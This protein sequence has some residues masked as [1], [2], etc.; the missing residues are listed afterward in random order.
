MLEAHDEVSRRTR[1]ILFAYYMLRRTSRHAG[2]GIRNRRR[3]Q[4]S[5]AG[6]L[7]AFDLWIRQE[8]NA[9]NG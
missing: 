1:P 3:T 8:P 7:P 9:A 4:S 5:K 2:S 6:D